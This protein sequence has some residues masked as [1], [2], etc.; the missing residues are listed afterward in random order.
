MN[1]LSAEGVQ[2][3]RIDG[4]T[5]EVTGPDSEIIGRRALE[6]GVALSELRP[7]RPHFGRCLHGIDPGRRGIQLEYCCRA[8]RREVEEDDYSY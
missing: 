7:L 6:T 5:L 8:Q 3:R 4:Q 2:P 1:A